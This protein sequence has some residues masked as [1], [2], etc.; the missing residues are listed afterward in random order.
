MIRS[1]STVTRKYDR[2]NPSKPHCLTYRIPRCCQASPIVHPIHVGSRFTG[3]CG[4]LCAI[5]TEDRQP[6]QML[7]VSALHPSRSLMLRRAN[8]S[9]RALLSDAETSDTAICSVHL[10]VFGCNDLPDP[11]DTKVL[12]PISS[13]ACNLLSNKGNDQRHD[14]DESAPVL[15][16]R[17]TSRPRD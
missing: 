17:V 15:D 3:S 9:Y 2:K 12:F 1:D 6:T 11:L 14:Q 10:T 16:I 7:N 4:S 5:G 13:I 8:Q